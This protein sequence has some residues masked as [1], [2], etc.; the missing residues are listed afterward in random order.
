[1]EQRGVGH[2]QS[3]LEFKKPYQPLNIHNFR[4]SGACSVPADVGLLLAFSFKLTGSSEAVVI[5]EFEST[6]DLREGDGDGNFTTPLDW[7][8]QAIRAA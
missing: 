3:L 5:F 8:S 1:M 2:L 6:T 7:S 4:S